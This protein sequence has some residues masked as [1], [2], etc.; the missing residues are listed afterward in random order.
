MVSEAVKAFKAYREFR[1]EK[2]SKGASDDSKVRKTGLA[3]LR[4]GERVLTAG[5]SRQYSK[6]RGRRSRSKSR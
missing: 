5:Q 6:H 1:K 4:K 2:G 3:K